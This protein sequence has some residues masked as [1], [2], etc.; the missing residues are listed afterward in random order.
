MLKRIRNWFRNK[1]VLMI[2][3]L[4]VAAFFLWWVMKDI[5]FSELKKLTWQGLLIGVIAAA[6]CAVL[7]VCLTALRWRMLLKSQN[8]FISVYRA[9]SLTFQGSMFSMFMPGGAVGGI[10]FVSGLQFL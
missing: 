10:G 6:A 8:I 4:A 1:Y 3:R 2:L 7:Q 5:R 9:L